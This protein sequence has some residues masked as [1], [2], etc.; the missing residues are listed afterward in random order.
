MKKGEY[1]GLRKKFAK[2]LN[3]FLTPAHGREPLVYDGNAFGL[4]HA[5]L[6]DKLEL[7]HKFSVS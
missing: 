2:R 7:L 4:I 5:L 3:T 6:C 1:L